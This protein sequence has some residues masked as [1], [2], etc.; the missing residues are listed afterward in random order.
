MSIGEKLGG[1]K[2]FAI[3]AATAPMTFLAAA[4]C[5]LV[6]GGC[7]LGGACLL[8]SPVAFGMVLVAQKK[9]ERKMFKALEDGTEEG[10]FEGDVTSDAKA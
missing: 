2:A 3:A 10:T 7:P 1:M 8:A 5:G 6:C 9:G 4:P